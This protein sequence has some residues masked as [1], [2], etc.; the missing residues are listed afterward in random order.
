MPQ[1]NAT[2]R[3]PV[4]DAIRIPSRA[5]SAAE[6]RA[7]SFTEEDR[8]VEIVW[9]AGASVKRYSWDEGYYMEELSM[10]PAHIRMDR[11][12]AMS[13]LDSH[14]AYSM[15]YRI[16]TVV[17]GTVRIENGRAYARVKLSRNA[18]GEDL[19]Q[20]LRDGMPFPVSV[21]YKIHAY[22][23]KEGDDGQLPTLRAIDWEPLELS[24]VP[25]SAQRR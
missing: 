22:E 5:I 9:A 11:F 4:G 14:D 21:G 15:D 24:A 8:T 20:D 10:D 1:P 23:K 12:T 6:V 3:K 17:P 16:G 13:L 25:I 7:E 19:F 2:G 18:R